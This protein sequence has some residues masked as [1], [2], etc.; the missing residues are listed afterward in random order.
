VAL[1]FWYGNAATRVLDQQ[2][3]EQVAEVFINLFVLEVVRC[4]L[5]AHHRLIIASV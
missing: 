4:S 1:D 3:S 2:S 5:A